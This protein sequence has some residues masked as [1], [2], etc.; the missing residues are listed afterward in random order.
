MTFATTY[1]HSN[2]KIFDLS[3]FIKAFTFI[4]Y[5]LILVFIFIFLSLEEFEWAIFSSREQI[6]DEVSDET[7]W[8]I[9]T[10]I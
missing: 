10:L 3:T 4:V 8:N 7:P 2:R 1:S 6:A 9:K 5:N